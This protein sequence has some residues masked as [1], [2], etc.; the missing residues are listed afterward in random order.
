VFDD[1]VKGRVEWSNEELDDLVLIRSDGFP[2]YNFAVVVDDIDMK[3]GEVIRGDDHVNNTPRQINIYHA[4]GAPVPEF[5]HLPMILGPDGQKLSKR[6]GAVG[7]MQYRD[8]GFLPHALLN[9]LVRLGWSHG[10][11]EIFSR[12]EMISMF[13]IADVN[14][15]ASR[16][17]LTKLEWLNQQYLKSDDPLEIAPH[18]EWH[19]RAAG[20]D[21][22]QG[23]DPVDV[24]VALRDRA[25]TLKEMAEKARVWYAPLDQYDETAVTKHLKTPTARAALEAAHAQL[26]ALSEWSVANVHAAIE[27][28]AQSIG[29]GMGKVAQPLRV[30]LTGTQVSPSI[31]HTTFLA[32]RD[33]ALRRIE[34][35]IARAG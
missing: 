21:P 17:D 27:A 29:E 34:A 32:G 13:D 18:F 15:S 28:A 20:I 16:F 10:D 23:P 26:A 11:Q 1:K 31:D 5:A 6:H 4:L 14:K 25:K 2:T 30:A 35:A 19:L 9:Y 8:D 12:A 7:V 24:I 3:I 33:E 22:A